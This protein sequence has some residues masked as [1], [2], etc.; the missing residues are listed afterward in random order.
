M[1][2]YLL[3]HNNG[4]ITLSAGVLRKAKLKEGDLLKAVVEEDGSIRLIH[5]TAIEKALAEKYQFKDIAWAR[6]KGSKK[7]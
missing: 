7:K 4:Q 2:K 6:Q 3:I 1:S 5:K